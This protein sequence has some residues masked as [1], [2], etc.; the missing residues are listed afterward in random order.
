MTQPHYHGRGAKFKLAF[1]PQSFGRKLYRERFGCHIL[2]DLLTASHILG[3]NHAVGSS[4][5]AV[6]H[7]DV[8]GNLAKTVYRKGPTLYGIPRQDAQCVVVRLSYV[9]QCDEVKVG[10]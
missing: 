1:R 10:R 3:E 4:F 2:R 6:S 5:Q 7:L 9:R 8:L